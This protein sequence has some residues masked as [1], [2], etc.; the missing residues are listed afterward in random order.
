M[1]ARML[2]V[3]A[4]LVVPFDTLSAGLVLALASEGILCVLIGRALGT[5][6]AATAP[7]AARAAPFVAEAPAAVATLAGGEPSVVFLQRRMVPRLRRHR[8]HDVV[9]PQIRWREA[10]EAAATR[11]R[12]GA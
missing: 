3:L 5:R 12:E 10:A 2:A 6:R 7:A 8:P 4:A 1:A 11:R 9:E